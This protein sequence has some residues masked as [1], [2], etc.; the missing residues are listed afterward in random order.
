M[1]LSM[2]AAPNPREERGKQIAQSQGQVFR[3]T[4]GYYKVKLQAVAGKR[5]EILITDSLKSYHDA[6]NK[7]FY[8]AR[9]PQS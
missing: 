7:V 9:S 1:Y 3:V 2:Q 8:T 4:D 6:F 5:P